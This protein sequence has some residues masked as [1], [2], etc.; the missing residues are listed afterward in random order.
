MHA[1]VHINVCAFKCSRVYTKIMIMKMM[2]EI[3]YRKSDEEATYVIF[4]SLRL[5]HVTDCSF[6]QVQW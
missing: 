3:L 5:A 2:T 6:F 4:S 1:C